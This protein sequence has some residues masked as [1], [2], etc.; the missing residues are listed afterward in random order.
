MEV[1]H[2]DYLAFLLDPTKNHG[3]GDLFLKRLVQNILAAQGLAQAASGR[4]I[5]L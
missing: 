2:S 4:S 5:L 1:R 3:L